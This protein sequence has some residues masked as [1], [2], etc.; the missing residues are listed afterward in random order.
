MSLQ[1]LQTFGE[2]VQHRQLIA[3]TVNKIMK[4]RANNTGSFTLSANTTTSIVT[5]PAFESSMVPQWTPTTSTA[6]TAMANLRVTTRAKGSFTL[7]H[8]NTA[9][10]DK[11]FLYVRWG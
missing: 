2:E 9:D 10:A 1:S 6:A 11:T 3:D 4:G 8:A 7:T 5:D